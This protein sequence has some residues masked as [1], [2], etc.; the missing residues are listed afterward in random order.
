MCRDCNCFDTRKTGGAMLLLH[1]SAIHWSW[2]ENVESGR[3]NYVVL[4][5]S[6]EWLLIKSTRST[7]WIGYFLISNS[8]SIFLGI[9][10][11]YRPKMML[12]FN[13]IHIAI[14]HPLGTPCWTGLVRVRGTAENHAL[15][16]P[17]PYHNESFPKGAGWLLGISRSSMSHDRPAQWDGI[18][19]T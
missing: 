19:R 15:P 4:D 7:W 5:L 17:S 18:V 1:Y 13:P 6:P 2:E 11:I 16:V 9:A 10:L 14:S 8:W 3:L 12:G